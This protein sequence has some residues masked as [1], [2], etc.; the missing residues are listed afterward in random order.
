MDLPEH[1]RQRRIRAVIPQPA[2]QAALVPIHEKATPTLLQKGGARAALLRGQF[3]CQEKGDATI[4]VAQP[5]GGGRLRT[6]Q[7]ATRPAV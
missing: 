4:S 6:P 5:G 2:D 3:N 7:A 1:F